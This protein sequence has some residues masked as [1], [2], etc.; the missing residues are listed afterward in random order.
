MNMTQ[1]FRAMQGNP[2]Q[3]VMQQ[4]IK[5]N[6]QQWQQAQQMFNGKSHEEQVATLRELYEKQGMDLD[7]TAK[8]YGVQL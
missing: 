3:F 5:E 2:Q 1:M 4:L 6:P 7:A 8:Q